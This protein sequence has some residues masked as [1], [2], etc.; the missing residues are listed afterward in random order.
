MKKK[1][2]AILVGISILLFFVI[3]SCLPSFS[4]FYLLIDDFETG[5][6]DTWTATGTTMATTTFLDVT[7]YQGDYMALLSTGP[8]DPAT[9]A[10]IYKTVNVPILT[11]L[12]SLYWQFITYEASGDVYQDYFK[13]SIIDSANNEHVIFDKAVD[14]FFNDYTMMA[15]TDASN[16]EYYRTADWQLFTYDISAF[17]GQNIKLC[18]EVGDV[19]DEYVDSIALI[20]LVELKK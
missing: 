9:F 8:E 4:L 20:D 2:T 10:R 13:I 6:L 11:S 7:P 5:M 3:T 16:N 12:L 14:D 19:E 15:A 17:K 1:V 18:F